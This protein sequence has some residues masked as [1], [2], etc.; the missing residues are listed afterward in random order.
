[1]SESETSCCSNWSKHTLK[2]QLNTIFL[3]VTISSLIIVGLSCVL[4]Q[5]MAGTST[6]N[7]VYTGFETLS[8]NDMISIVSDGAKFFDEK[9][10]KLTS[11]FPNLMSNSIED[12]Y[13][14][15]YPFG[16]IKSYYNWPNT[17]VDQHYLP[18]YDANVTFSH[19]SYNV[20]G[21]TINN[22]PS[23]SPNIQ[24]LINRTSSADYLFVPS[25]THSNDFFAGYLATP[26]QVLRYY[27]AAVNY[28]KLNDYIYYNNLNDNWYTEVMANPD[29]ITYTS[30]YYDPIAKKPMIT[31][32]KVVKNP[33]TGTQIGAFGSDLILET[34]QNDIKDLIY[35]N[36][37]RTI[38]F[39]KETGYVIADSLYDH[40]ALI[41]YKNL[42]TPTISTDLWN[43]L[44][45]GD[46]QLQNNGG[47]YYVA[48]DME[49]S[50]N[51]YMLV[52]IIKEKYITDQFLPITTEVDNMININIY[53]VVGIF[54]GMLC[55][56]SL[57]TYCL[58]NRIVAPLQKLSDISGQ[59]TQNIGE[60]SLLANVNTNIQRSGVRELDEVTYHFQQSVNAISAPNATSTS[61]DYYHNIPWVH[62]HAVPS[63][64]PATVTGYAI[65][66]SKDGKH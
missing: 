41:T 56:I 8:K 58:T 38:L 15:D 51:K 65:V 4:F 63:A 24:N 3:N 55:L 21:K 14:T 34:L 17:F 2:R 42:N 26:E 54:V 39:E 64:P 60:R 16:Y 28:V 5:Y 45:N 66:E 44:I 1:M 57:L 23:L 11:N 53:V 52:S 27:P 40:N 13:R 43:D 12:S 48:V 36:K 10:S 22:V 6:H 20:Y 35:L 46:K 30:P 33:H 7:E 37:S 29:Q 25:F 49:T 32:G 19:S 61:N 62:A 50:D 18:S 47:Y 31:I 59:M 9:L